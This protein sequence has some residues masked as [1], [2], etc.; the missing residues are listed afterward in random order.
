MARRMEADLAGVDRDAGR[1]GRH[2]RAAG[3]L[4]RA[5]AEPGRVPERRPQVGLRLVRGAVPGRA[6]QQVDAHRTRHQEQVIDIGF[7]VPDAHD[8]RGRTRGFGADPGVEAGQPFLA[9]F[10][11]ER[12]PL[13]RGT[14]PHRRRLT[15]PDLL[16]QQ[17]QRHP[18]QA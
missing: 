13:A 3:H 15:C 11:R 6:H 14:L 8:L 12:A 1:A 18:L 7:A 16:L 9:L 10:L 2:A 17:P 5:R 4:D